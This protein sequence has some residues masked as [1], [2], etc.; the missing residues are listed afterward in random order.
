MGF[1]S[2]ITTED[3][4]NE[5]DGVVK[6]VAPVVLDTSAELEDEKVDE[7]LEETIEDEY[8]E[9]LLISSNQE[10]EDSD[11]LEEVTLASEVIKKVI[12]NN[13]E[14][15]KKKK[16]E[17]DNTALVAS[18]NTTIITAGSKIEGNLVCDN[19]CI[20]YGTVNGSV[21]ANNLTIEKNAVVSSSVQSEHSLV[22]KGTIGTSFVKEKEDQYAVESLE[23][24]QM[25]GCNVKGNVYAKEEITIDENSIIVGNITATGITIEKGAIKGNL[26]IDGPVLLKAGAIVK[27]NIKSAEITMEKGAKVSGTVE[28]CYGDNNV[29]DDALFN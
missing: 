8:E 27:G 25:V 15:E 28:Q 9:E 10:E 7:I 17:V 6:E 16:K 11:I 22:I 12:S 3:I 4:M 29:I 14:V 24:I 1:F 18:S 5:D 19:D 26:D 23:T 21:N 20:V 13:K 2:D